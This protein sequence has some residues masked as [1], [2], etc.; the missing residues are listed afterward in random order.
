MEHRKTHLRGRA[1]WLGGEIEI[2]GWVYNIGDGA[3]GEA[4]SAGGS[5]A[6]IGAAD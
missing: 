6:A 2:R 5:L 3:T 1:P 4:E